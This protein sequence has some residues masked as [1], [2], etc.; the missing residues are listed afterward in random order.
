MTRTPLILDGGMGRELE[1]IGA[2]F[3]QPFWSA[4]AL[5]EAPDMVA[6]A[7]RNF[8]EA[9]AQ[10]ITTNSY[11]V[12]PPHVG[13]DLFATRGAEL[14]ELSARLAREEA[15]KASHP[16]QVAA[17]VP[18]LFGSYHPENF[19]AAKARELL[20]PFFEAQ[21]PYADLFLVETIGCLE[22]ALTAA[23]I[24]REHGAGK[25]LWLAF[26]LHEFFGENRRPRLCSEEFVHDIL[27]AVLDKTQAQAILFNC[28]PVEDV[29][30]AL[31]M[32]HEA[33]DG[34]TDIALG[35]YANAFTKIE[36]ERDPTVTSALRKDVTP[37]YY[38]GFAK[39][40]TAAGATIIG[41]CCGI[42]PEHLEVLAKELCS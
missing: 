12:V 22:E 40:W 36:E 34:R 13:D 14:I 3:S 30:P 25:P 1:R 19:D 9:G 33:L 29:A 10:V 23:E 20:V 2:P 39:E 16:V 41:G 32:A 17:C 5:M 4:Q 35:A 31:A 6:L 8:I 37:E 7:H 11:A 38:L 18:P 15:D 27:P 24:H 26:T 21:A 28:C 42:G